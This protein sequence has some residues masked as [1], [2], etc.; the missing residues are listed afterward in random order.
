MLIQEQVVAA[1]LRQ[2]HLPQEIQHIHPL[3]S[4]GM[5]NHVALISDRL[6]GRVARC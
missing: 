6:G 4:S 5:T 2:A 1:L 3:T